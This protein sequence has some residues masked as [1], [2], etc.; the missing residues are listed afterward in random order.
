MSVDINYLAV[1]LAGVSSMIV[2]SIWY[3]KG[4]F[5]R[6][7]GKLAKVKM[8]GEANFANMAPL[9]LQVFV[10]SLITAYIL[11]HFMFL[12]R[13]FFGDSWISTGLTTAFWAWLG[14]TAARIFT[15]DVFENRPKALTLL[16]FGNE[17]V[18]LLVM[19]LV[20]GWLHP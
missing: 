14:F 7:W 20:L 8:D 10:A 2:G 11:A 15:H 9:L 4:V 17:L 1:F 16:N 3:A 13:H 12:S 18:T 5:G 6:T 19:G